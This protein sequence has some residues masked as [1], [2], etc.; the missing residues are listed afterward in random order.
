MR[1]ALYRHFDVDGV[2]LYAGISTSPARRYAEHSSK[3]DWGDDI[4]RMDIEWFPGRAA[5]LRAESACIRKELPLWN[6]QKGQRGM[7]EHLAA[8]DISTTS[9]PEEAPL[10]AWIASK[11][12]RRKQMADHLGI[13]AAYMS[14]ICNQV[15]SPGL[16]T[17]IAIED[18]TMGEV[19]ARGLLAAF[20]AAQGDDQ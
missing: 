9:R 20:Q 6:I 14:D 18:F 17:A 19:T 15:R 8:L 11:G 12:I 1:T 13:S 5:A 4:R 7:A 3:S 2:L 16:K 10:S